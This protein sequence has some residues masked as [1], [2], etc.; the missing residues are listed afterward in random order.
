MNTD[1]S[2]E[3]RIDILL[4]LLERVVIYTSERE[5]NPED[6]SKRDRADSIVFDHQ[7]SSISHTEIFIE[8]IKHSCDQL[9]QDHQ[10]KDFPESVQKQIAS[11]AKIL[12]S[13]TYGYPEAGAMIVD[14][15]A[16]HLSSLN[17]L[18]YDSEKMFSS[19]D[20]FIV[21]FYCERFNN[22]AEGAS[23]G[24]KNLLSE[25]TKIVCGYLSR[26]VV[27]ERL[28]DESKLNLCRTPVKISLTILAHICKF[29]ASN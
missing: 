6:D 5:L 15:F 19:Q 11:I 2:Q 23:P 16:P 4:E 28:G 21:R 9:I 18:E 25:A 7:N 8:K 26:V 13:L 20:K 29:S 12:P 22:V 24:V 10:D 3:E 27:E 1:K 14:L 17:I